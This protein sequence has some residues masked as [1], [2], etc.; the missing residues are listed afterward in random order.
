MANR[1]ISGIAALAVRSWLVAGTSFLISVPCFAGLQKDEMTNSSLTITVRVFNYAGTSLETWKS[2]QII[3]TR[4]FNRA[5]IEPIWITCS[6]SSDG[7]YLVQDCAAIPRPD[8]IIL[9][10]VPASK[11]SRAHFGN[12]TLGIAALFEGGTPASASVFY[13]RVEELAKGGAAPVAVILGHAAAHEIGHL[14]LG[15]KSDS[16]L[17]LMCGRWSRS[18]LTLANDGQLDFLP[19]EIVSIQRGLRLRSGVV[20]SVSQK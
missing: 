5:G 9:R 12:S 19:S 2:A 13:N 8:D 4:I 7:Q 3:A 1:L 17:G 16:S 11:A 18:S 20:A 6:L 15:S 10:L 14:L